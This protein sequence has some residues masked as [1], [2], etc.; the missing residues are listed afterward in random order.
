VNVHLACAAKAETAGEEYNERKKS[1]SEADDDGFPS[2]SIDFFL[3]FPVRSS[4]RCGFGRGNTN[5][6]PFVVD[7]SMAIPH[8]AY[9]RVNVS[10]V[11]LSICL[12]IG[13]I[14]P[15]GVVIEMYIGHF[16]MRYVH[17][18]KSQGLT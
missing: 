18:D 8:S 6:E 7:G 12:F 14:Y 5:G 2:S 4:F 11:R 9:G 3:Y 10:F 17:F 16:E 15:T 13:D 1:E